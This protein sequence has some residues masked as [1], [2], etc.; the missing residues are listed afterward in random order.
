ML[1]ARSASSRSGPDGQIAIFGSNTLCASLVDA[2]LI[3]EFQIM[4]NPVVLGGG[5]SLFR[6]LTRRA[7]LVLDTSRSHPARS[8]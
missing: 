7:E 3:D 5:T 6:G 8:C 1:S 2:G 4:V